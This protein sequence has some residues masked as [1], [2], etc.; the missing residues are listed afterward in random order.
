[1][2]KP[3]CKLITNFNYWRLAWRKGELSSSIDR[4]FFSL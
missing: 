1:M 4:N 2:S 3:S